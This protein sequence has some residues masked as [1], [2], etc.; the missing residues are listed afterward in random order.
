MHATANNTNNINKLIKNLK[1]TN[2]K[3]MIIANLNINSIA[4]KFD[5]LKTVINNHVDILVLVETK[6]QSC[7]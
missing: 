4:N 5:K 7:S 3:K 1:I 2:L 6:L